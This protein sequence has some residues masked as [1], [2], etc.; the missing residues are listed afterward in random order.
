V[1]QTS[2]RDL[3]VRGTNFTAGLAF[4]SGPDI[5]VSAITLI[6]GTQVRITVQV[7]V[8]AALGPRNVTVSTPGGTSNSVVL[9]V[10]PPPPTLTSIS[11]S[12]GAQQSIANVTL[13]GTNFVQ[14][15][16]IQGPFPLTFS[17]VMVTDSTSATA[18]VTIPVNTQTGNYNI[19]ATTASGTSGPVTFT[20]LPGIPTLT[21]VRP[22]FAIRG[23][24]NV[25]EVVGTNFAEGSTTISPVPG[26]L[27]TVQAVSGGS[28]SAVFEVDA[29]V[30]LGSHSITVTTP[31]GTTG[32]VTFSIFDPFPDLSV[33]SNQANL[34]AG[35]N[36]TYAL[37]LSNTGTAAATTP[38]TITDTLPAGLTFVSAS[39]SGY[40][41]LANGQVVNCTYTNLPFTPLS[42]A[43]V[44]ITVAVGASVSGSTHTFSV[45]YAQD[46]L[47][48]NNTA[49]AIFTL[50]QPPTPVLTFAP[51]NLVAGQQA[52]VS[53]TIP[54]ALPQ[55]VTGTLNLSFSS[56]ASNPGDDP[57]I[58]F[59]TGGRQVSFV[60]AANTTQARFGSSISAGPIGFQTG[61]VAGS[62]A[63]T[64]VA[65]MGTIQKVFSSTSGTA[66]LAIA[67]AA[68]VLQSVR[69][70]A[71][72]GVGILVTSSSTARSVTEM[73]LQFNT[74]P[75][76]D[77]SCGSVA[78][79]T[80]SGSTLTLDVKA[81]FDMWFSG[82]SQFGSL[83]TLRIPLVIQGT[84]H[85]SVS[86]TFRN[87]LGSSNAMSVSF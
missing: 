70:E 41:C 55:A 25:M 60:I 56:S 73:I 57:A 81:L 64:G 51:T 10:L 82:D 53:V 76:V 24:V 26:V 44:T 6:S 68:P 75:R 62:L 83:N 50:Q 49:S 7:G 59:A 29:T 65:Q 2:T 87:A 85:G 9:T 3:D 36:G 19:R 16:T 84:I 71:E 21:E 17:Q 23:R 80:A 48:S 58:Q 66:S 47:P 43:G 42:T 12:S 5:T 39:G 13:I 32:A 30:S 18:V 54:T 1:P 27:I 15:L 14:G 74:T 34:L 37:S 78:G 35:F 20:V 46:L 22:F 86:V 11:P 28:L 69:R 38:I 61:T 52:T 63:F 8:A 31:G 33:S 72:P 77:P 40:S 67:P 4:D 79:C 45:P